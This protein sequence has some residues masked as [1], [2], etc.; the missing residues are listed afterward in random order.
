MGPGNVVSLD[1]QVN[2]GL[3]DGTLVSPP[4][5]R[6]KFLG[7]SGPNKQNSSSCQH[8]SS[9]G[10]KGN[11]TPRSICLQRVSNTS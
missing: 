2:S 11:F 7:I 4:P 10:E 9:S 3:E 1:H 8:L 6:N 5:A